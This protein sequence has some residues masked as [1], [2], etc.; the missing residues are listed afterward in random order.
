MR[1]TF[2]ILLTLALLVTVCALPAQAMASMDM[3]IMA[4][5]E[6][7]TVTLTEDTTLDAGAY[8]ENVECDGHT[9]TLGEGAKLSGA[10]N[11]GRLIV[12]AGAKWTVTGTSKLSC[13]SLDADSVIAGSMGKA[14]TMT[15]DGIIDICRYALI[16]HFLHYLWNGMNGDIDTSVDELSVLL[17]DI[18]E[19]MLLQYEE[20]DHE[21]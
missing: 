4:S 20:E 13:L 7:E 1:K 11:G 3:A 16:G 6:A 21:P 17:N 9:L 14:A 18:V 5:N 2:S 19:R 15:V 12:G 10:V 8:T